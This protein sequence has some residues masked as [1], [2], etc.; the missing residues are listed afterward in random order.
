MIELTPNQVHAGQL[1]RTQLG[2][3]EKK[4]FL[5]WFQEWGRNYR[6]FEFGVL[7]GPPGL[8]DPDWSPAIAAMAE[9]VSRLR[10]DVVAFDGAKWWIIEIKPQA[11]VSAIGQL[12]SYAHFWR[13]EKPERGEPVLALIAPFLSEPIK[14]IAQQTDLVLFH[15]PL[16]EAP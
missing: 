4:L 6:A 16:E 9:K 3:L 5:S 2:P 12:Q 10:P 15:V 11:R 13:Q 8:Q 14:V 1:V 7:L